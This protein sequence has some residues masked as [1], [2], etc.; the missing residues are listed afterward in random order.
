MKIQKCKISGAEFEISDWEVEFLR[1]I[2]PEGFPLP[3]PELCPDERMR[4]RT[5]Q[6]NEDKLHRTQ[7]L[8]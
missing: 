3:L 1:K 6:R 4:L 8:I 5:M 7:G 2:S